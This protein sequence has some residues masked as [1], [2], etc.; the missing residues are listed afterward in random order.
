[1]DYVIPYIFYLLI[2]THTLE[3]SVKILSSKGLSNVFRNLELILKHINTNI[4]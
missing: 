3:T 2:P 1:M 4:Q